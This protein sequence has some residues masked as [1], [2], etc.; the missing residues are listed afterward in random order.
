MLFKWLTALNILSEAFC[1]PAMR[2]RDKYIPIKSIIAT[3]FINRLVLAIFFITITTNILFVRKKFYTLSLVLIP[4]L[5]V[6][7]DLQT[8]PRIIHFKFPP[9]S[10]VSDWY[11]TMSHVSVIASRVL[12][13]KARALRPMARAVLPL[14][15]LLGSGLVA[16]AVTFVDQL[17]G[18]Y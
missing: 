13:L 6:S 18:L 7:D 16:A 3:L 1:S 17:I 11:K 5:S 9:S 4:W 12:H 8:P 10:P 14:L 2:S 15:L